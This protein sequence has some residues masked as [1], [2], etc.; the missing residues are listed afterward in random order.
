MQLKFSLSGPNECEDVLKLSEVDHVLPICMVLAPFSMV[1]SNTLAFRCG[2][3]V[4]F[5]SNIPQ[6]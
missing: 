6:P 2:Q 3:V 1:P 4:F 5:I